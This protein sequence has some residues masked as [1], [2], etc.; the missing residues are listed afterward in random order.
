MKRRLKPWHCIIVVLL[1]P[2]VWFTYIGGAAYIYAGYLESK[3]VPADPKTKEDLEKHLR[4][5]YTRT[6]DPKESMWGKRYLLSDGE[7]MIQYCILWHRQCPLDVVY[8]NDDNIVRI[9][10]SY[11]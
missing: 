3:W 9:F 5:Y 7:R 8:D 4:L 11:E 6:I 2:L 1:I 10:T